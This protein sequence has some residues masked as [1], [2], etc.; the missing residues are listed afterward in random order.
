MSL[1]RFVRISV[2]AL[3]VVLVTGSLAL[4]SHLTPM[5]V[6]AEW[7]FDVNNGGNAVDG[8]WD[9]FAQY[10]L[11]QG[12]TLAI[13]LPRTV[14]NGMKVRILVSGDARLDI[15]WWDSVTDDGAGASGQNQLVSSATPTWIEF[16]QAN[17]TEVNILQI[18]QMGTVST[19]FKVYEVEVYGPGATPPVLGESDHSVGSGNWLTDGVSVVLTVFSSVLAKAIEPPLSIFVAAGVIFLVIAMVRRLMSA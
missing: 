6:K 15:A 2:V 14:A 5:S 16:T 9:T 1:L 12:A 19:A 4:A 3:V 18:D 13:N 7:T 10:D 17:G 8:D 11:V